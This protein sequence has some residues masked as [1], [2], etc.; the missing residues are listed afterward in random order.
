MSHGMPLTLNE[1]LATIVP[2]EPGKP[3]EELERELGLK[4]TI[5][6][7]SNENPQGPSPHALEAMRQAASRC[8][9]YPDGGAYYL[10]RRLARDLDVPVE[11]L[12]IGNGSTEIVEML[13]KAFLP[14]DGVS[15][16]SEG[17]FIMYRIATLAAS[18]PV[19]SVPMTPDRRHDLAAMA[20]AVA[21]ATRLVF[22][23]N[24]N[25]PTG[26]RCDRS[27]FDAYLDQVPRTVLT[28]VDE[29]YREY[30]DDR[31]Y[32][33][34]CEAL[35]NGGAVMVLRTFSKI[36]AL[37]GARIGYGI[38]HPDIIRALEKVRSPFNTNSIGQAGALAS[39][40][41]R[42]HQI[43]SSTENRRQL[44]RLEA[45]LTRRGLQFLPSSTNFVLMAPGFP[46]RE[47]FQALLH[48]GVIV[49]PMDG[50]GFQDHVRVSIGCG[51][52][53]DRFL[54]ALD[55]VRTERGLHAA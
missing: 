42:E 28:V 12:I 2:Y 21:P 33:D 29:A 24:P 26:T 35:R 41:D 53:M 22:I 13:T 5:K 27:E 40:D 52:E 54:L 38:A 4:E 1:H 16:V 44:N 14:P 47:A 31:D 45:E 6:L 49:R 36:H 51:P 32:P 17:A 9:R 46:G 25:N 3:T 15:L 34:A 55:K 10:K 50:Y 7:A 11:W 18:A 20:A 23:A 43:Q 39:L 30:I 19:C 37:A 8:H 48:E